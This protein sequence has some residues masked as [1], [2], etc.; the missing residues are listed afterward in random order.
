MH[1]QELSRIALRIVC[2]QD[3][4]GG[5]KGRA[6][7]EFALW[8]AAFYCL[9]GGIPTVRRIGIV[10][11]LSLVA[12]VMFVSYGVAQGDTDAA[13][14]SAEDAKPAPAASVPAGYKLQTEDVVK[15]AV[16]GEPNLSLEQIVDPKGYIRLPLL[17]EIY[18]EGL[19]V[20]ELTNALSQ[21]LTKYLVEPKVQITLVR[22][23]QP[24]VY[25]LGQLRQPAM[26]EFDAGDRVMEAIALAGS[27]TEF[28]DLASATLTH[29]DSDVSCPLDLAKLFYEGD[30]SQNV[31]LEDGDTI[32]V[33]EDTKNKFYV[34]GEVVRPNMYRLKPNVTVVDAIAGA[35]GATE[36]G[37]LKATCVVRVSGGEKPERISVDVKKLL[38]DGDLAQNIALEPGDVV[39]VPETSKPDWREIAGI[40][41]TVVNTSYLFKVWGL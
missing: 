4:I 40:L 14:G 36:R 1:E 16:W 27:F 33:P 15:I 11:F 26:Y 13:V 2:R 34:L 24:R 17:G 10:A 25:M 28:A 29:R 9:M 8:N 21:G 38:K 6:V 23:R 35:G 20:E 7:H 3:L 32:Y 30:M 22:F 39:Y 18:A 5:F 31:V 37:N 12:V 19:T 41:S